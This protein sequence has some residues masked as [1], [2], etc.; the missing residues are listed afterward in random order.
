MEDISRSDVQ[1]D[2]ERWV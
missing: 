1:F 2:D